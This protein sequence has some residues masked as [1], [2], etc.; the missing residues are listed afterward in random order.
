MS[1]H[2]R[3]SK[4]SR[5]KLFNIVEDLISSFDIEVNKVKL[6][7]EKREFLEVK[8]EFRSLIE[9]NENFKLELFIKINEKKGFIQIYNQ[10]DAKIFG[11]IELDLFDDNPIILLEDEAFKEKLDKFGESHKKDLNRVFIDLN[12]E[13]D[14]N[15]LD[16]LYEYDV[17]GGFAWILVGVSQLREIR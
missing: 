11:D 13:G 16:V 1:L 2:I 5:I 17:N 7:G 6:N 10:Y 3:S 15:P 8:R 12:E 14:E 4:L 9:N